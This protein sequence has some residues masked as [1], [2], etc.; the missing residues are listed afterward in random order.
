MRHFLLMRKAS[1]RAAACTA[2]FLSTSSPLPADHT[3]AITCAVRWQA[4]SRS[5]GRGG[6]GG[7]GRA[8]GAGGSRGGGATGGSAAAKRP[9]EVDPRILNKTKDGELSFGTRV[10][11][12]DDSI[13]L[14][15][16][17]KHI[18]QQGAISIKS[19]FSALNEDVQ[20]ALSERH[21]GLRNFVEQR[22]QIFTVRP[23]PTDGVLYVLGN[24]LVAQ[25]YATRELQLKTMRQMMGL[26]EGNEQQQKQRR[27]GSFSGS[28]GGGSG[29]RGGGNHN[30]NYRRESNGDDR[31]ESQGRDQR[32][33]QGHSNSSSNNEQY[34]S[35]DRRRPPQPRDDRRSYGGGSR[36][37]NYNNSG[38]PQRRGGGPMGSRTQS[39]G[40]RN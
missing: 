29:G 14:T 12:R 6:G 31:G 21:G 39:F 25:Q 32:R 36:S 9:D 23:H 37:S 34:G 38:P 10:A 16:V 15:D 7:G 13:I 3:S 2:G 33:Y 24:P 30:R 35:N 18:P 19:L 8:G 26:S 28:R 17:F 40:T 4:Q 1:P 22:K 11:M 27:P 5:Y 20:E